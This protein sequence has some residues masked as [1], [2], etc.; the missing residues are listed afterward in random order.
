MSDN[1]HAPTLPGPVVS[2]EWL[3]AN[4]GRPGLRVI[5]GTWYMHGSGRDARSDFNQRHIPGAVFFDIDDVAAQDSGGLPHMVPPPDRFAEKVSALGVGDD[6]ALV[7][8]DNHG[9]QTAGRAWWLFRLFGH[10]NVAILD[11][12]FPKWLAEKREIQTGAPTPA[13]GVFTPKLQPG[14]LRRIDEIAENVESGA[15]QLVDA[16]SRGRFEATAA[17]SWAQGKRGHIPGSVNLPFTDLLNDADKTFL[18]ADAVAAKFAAA[19]VDLDKPLV[20]TCGSGV[21]ACVLAV[22]AELLGKPAVAIYDG[23]WAEWGLREDLPFRT[24]PAGRAA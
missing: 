10:G 22:G 24:G 9:F 3:A 23:S 1:A 15:F 19:G 20:A 18:T 16:R 17:E 12:G 13:P 21:T 6:D 11:G 5:D 14:L 8:Y 7:V 4:L 2:T